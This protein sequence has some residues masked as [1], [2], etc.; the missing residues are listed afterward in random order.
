MLLGLNNLLRLRLFRTPYGSDPRR[1]QEA[2]RGSLR[3]GGTDL[4]LALIELIDDLAHGCLIQIGRSCQRSLRLCGGRERR[5]HCG[6]RRDES[7]RFRR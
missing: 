5:S 4:K 3:G 7:R 6:R 1:E 2:L